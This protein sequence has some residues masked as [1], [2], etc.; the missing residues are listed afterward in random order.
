MY[1]LS[2]KF[3]QDDRNETVV[4]QSWT[5]DLLFNLLAHSVTHEIVPPD[6][7]Q[8]RHQWGKCG[9]FFKDRMIALEHVRSC[10]NVFIWRCIVPFEEESKKDSKKKKKMNQD[11][12]S[13]CNWGTPGTSKSKARVHV[14]AHKNKNG[15]QLIP[16]GQL[17]NYI[18]ANQH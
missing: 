16:E 8:V 3:A 7:A 17:D 10:C 4:F 2:D 11:G 15:G 9:K 18:Q 13:W 6:K 12:R 1:D 5:Y 14:R